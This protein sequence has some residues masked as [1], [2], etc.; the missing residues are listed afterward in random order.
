MPSTVNGIRLASHKSPPLR[1]LYDGEDLTVVEARKRRAPMVELR[2]RVNRTTFTKLAKRA[3]EVEVQ[4]EPFL[5]RVINTVSEL[6]SI[7]SKELKKAG[8]DG[9]NLEKSN[10]RMASRKEFN[11]MLEEV[12][13]K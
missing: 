4:L 6:L 1:T 11:Q 2:L 8:V 9:L 5:I 10:Y 7:D 3:R 12:C 13:K